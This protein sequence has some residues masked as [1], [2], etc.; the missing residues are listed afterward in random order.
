M[1]S[2]TLLDT[3]DTDLIEITDRNNQKYAIDHTTG[4]GCYGATRTQALLNLTVKLQH[5]TT[6]NPAHP[7]RVENVLNTE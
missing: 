5:K 1:N 3:T 6:R 7:D 4:D 2:N